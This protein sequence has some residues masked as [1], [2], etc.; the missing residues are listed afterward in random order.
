MENVSE[1]QYRWLSI[2]LKILFPNRREKNYSLDK[3]ES[4]IAIK[5]PKKL[6][7]REAIDLYNQ[8]LV[9]NEKVLRKIYFSI[10]ENVSLKEF[11][12]LDKNLVH[13]G[14][15]RLIFL[16]IEELYLK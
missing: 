5:Y 9:L 4:L 10:S 16:I 11:I 8:L 6:K 15:C 3:I 14:K 13:L 2:T 7:Y 12:T 1:I